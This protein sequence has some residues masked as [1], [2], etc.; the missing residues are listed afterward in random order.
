MSLMGKVRTQLFAAAIILFVLLA[1]SGCIGGDTGDLVFVEKAPGARA[2]EREQQRPLTSS[3]EVDLSEPSLQQVKLC[4]LPFHDLTN[5][6]NFD[7][8][9][10]MFNQAIQYNLEDYVRAIKYTVYN[11]SQYGNLVESLGRSPA[12]QPDVDIARKIREQTGADF[13]LFGNITRSENQVRIEPFIISFEQGFMVRPMDAQPV[14]VNNF[15]AFM[16][17]Y[18]Q[19]LLDEIIQRRQG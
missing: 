9:K 2:N 4:V 18:V 7:Y 16:D 5:L 10:D 19:E 11:E 3:S 6:D 1:A 15:L 12:Q 13:I 14:S 17:S 8:F